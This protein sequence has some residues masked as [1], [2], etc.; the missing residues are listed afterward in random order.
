ML[1]M[2]WRFAER[3]QPFVAKP[4]LSDAELNDYLRQSHALVAMGL[5]KKKRVELG[6]A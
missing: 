3:P 4:G 5:S 1:R 6:L 2:K